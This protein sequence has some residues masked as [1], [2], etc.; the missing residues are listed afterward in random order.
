M[1]PGLVASLAYLPRIR[2]GQ[3]VQGPDSHMHNL[4]PPQPLHHLRLPHVHIGAVAQPEVVTLAPVGGQSMRQRVGTGQQR[5]TGDTHRLQP[6][7]RLSGNV[8]P[9]PRALCSS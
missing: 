6:Q 8:A 1:G 4:L 5:S 3:T 7:S 9:C 2:D